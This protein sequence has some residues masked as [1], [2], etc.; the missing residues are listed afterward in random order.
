MLGV[1]SKVVEWP[2]LRPFTTNAMLPVCRFPPAIPVR[3]TA[4]GPTSPFH[5]YLFF[6]GGLGFLAGGRGLGV[7]GRTLL[8]PGGRRLGSGFFV[9]IHD[10]P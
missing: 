1:P 4:L 7:P 3:L 9:L 8:T 6:G 5:G 2:H 10:P